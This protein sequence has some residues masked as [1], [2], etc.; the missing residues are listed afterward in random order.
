VKPIRIPIAADLTDRELAFGGTYGTDTMLVNCYVETERAT[1]EKFVVKR[2]GYA[3]TFTYNGGGATSAQGTTY[4]K[5]CIF[6]MGSNVLYRLN[7]SGVIGSNG[8][9]PWTSPL[10]GPWGG[11]SAFGCIV[12]NNQILVIAGQAFGGATW[13]NDIWGSVDGVSWTQLSA[14]APF[15]PRGAFGLAILGDVLYLV[16]GNTATYYTDVWSTTDGANWT[17]VCADTGWEPRQGGQLVAFGNSLVFTGGLTAITGVESQ[18]VWS[19]VDGI[20]WTKGTQNAPWAGR[21]QHTSLVY[22]N[23]I[24]VMGGRIGVLTRQDVWSSPDAINWTNTGNM[25]AT[26]SL[27]NACVY[28]NK[29]WLL[30]GN[31][32]AFAQTKTVWSTTDGITFTAVAADYSGGTG[33]AVA[34]AGMVVYRTP[35]TAGTFQGQSIWLL[36]GLT[37]IAYTSQ[38]WYAPLNVS[39]AS[40]FTPTGTGAATTEAWDFAQQGLGDYLIVKNTKDAWVL[41]SGILQKITSTN[42]PIVTVRGVVNLDDTV[43]VMDPLGQIFGSKLSTPFEWSSLNFITADYEADAPVAIAKYQNFLVAFKSFTTQFFYDAGRYPGSPLL[44]VINANMRVG[45]AAAGSIASVNNT[46]FFMA[47]SDTAGNYIAMF[48][49]Y[50]AVRVSTPDVDRILNSWIPDAFIFGFQGR[51]NGHPSYFLTLKG[52]NVTLV[53]DLDEKRWHT[54]ASGSAYFAGVNYVTDGTTDYLQDLLLGK[55]YG[56]SAVV[57]QDAGSTITVSALGDKIDGGTNKRKFC[58]N[59]TVIGDRRASSSPNTATIS[60]SDDDAQTFSTGITV[61]LTASRPR[62]NRCGSFRRRQHKI[63]HASNNPFRV[64][65]F[66]LEVITSG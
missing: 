57:Y 9:S 18:E 63:T 12:F 23:K 26:R 17:Q 66:E 27:M 2:P 46:L 35:S 56:L 64:K 11:R 10:S 29:M 55:I 28:S 38:I 5:G 33:Q 50:S 40:S 65:A 4:Y 49:G 20:T 43:Y 19:S 7:G 59:L 41:N 42:Y 32:A 8:A 14:A 1:G 62:I 15:G 34:D 22:Q 25:P 36:G 48:D 16:G 3:T 21:H 13:Y 44:P 45:C 58:S 60:W 37:P 30:G 53:F 54:W 31:D 61:D 6:A 47:R 52:A 24:W 51:Y 39:I